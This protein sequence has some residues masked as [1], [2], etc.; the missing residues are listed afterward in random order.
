MVARKSFVLVAGLLAS[1]LAG[2]STARHDRSAPFLRVMTFNIHHGEGTDGRVDLKRI[3]RVIRDSRADVVALQEVDRGVER[4]ERVDIMTELSDLTGMAYA[5]GKNIDYQGGLYG[6]GFLTRFPI[7]EERNHHYAMIRANEQRGALV[8][9]LDVRGTEVLVLNTHLD[10]REDDIERLQNVKEITTLLASRGT[11]P[12][13]VFGDFNDLPGSG[14]H[15]SLKDGLL[16]TWEKSGQGDG[17]TYPS[18]SPFKRIDYIFVTRID[19][20]SPGLVPL[21]S[22]V[23]ASDASDHL[24]LLV[25][26]DLQENWSRE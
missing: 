10:Y 25:T 20:Q 1:L 24:P 16:D 8:M 6:N 21:S 11:R 9:V 3:A 5:F 17:Y 15:T 19:N 14:T 13:I 18:G 22:R 23:L 12:A 4:T 7:L 2:C 26:L